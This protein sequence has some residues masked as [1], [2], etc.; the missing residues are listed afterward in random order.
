[1]FTFGFWSLVGLESSFDDFWAERMKECSEQN[2]LI[3]IPQIVF[4]SFL[5]F[6]FHHL[7]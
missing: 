1:L 7:C 4:D 6:F 2:L 5:R 3:G